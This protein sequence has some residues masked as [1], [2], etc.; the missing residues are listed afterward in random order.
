MIPAFWPFHLIRTVPVFCFCGGFGESNLALLDGCWLPG[1]PDCGEDGERPRTCP[2][3]GLAR[4]VVVAAAPS[5]AP[6][7]PSV[8]LMLFIYPL[9]FFGVECNKI[10]RAAGRWAGCGGGGG[11]GGW[12]GSKPSGGHLY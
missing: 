7:P 3:S 6:P 1:G 10:K 11:R 4:V 5:A 2:N 8:S 9:F 12:G